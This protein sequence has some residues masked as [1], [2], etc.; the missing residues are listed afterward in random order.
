[1][2]RHSR[3]AKTL[4]AKERAPARNVCQEYVGNLVPRTISKWI[5]RK[6]MAKVEKANI[7]SLYRLRGICGGHQS[8]PAQRR[9]S[10]GRLCRDF[11]KVK[12]RAR[13]ARA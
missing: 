6:G 7:S 5:A 10:G 8:G 11:L 12:E 2:T 3:I 13:T 1:M 4:K 9:I